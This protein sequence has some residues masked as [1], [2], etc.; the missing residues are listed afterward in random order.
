MHRPWYQTS[1]RLSHSSQIQCKC[2][3]YL[4]HRCATKKVIPQQLVLM[5]ALSKQ[6][7]TKKTLEGMLDP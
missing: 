4:I 5:G 3:S 1:M 2:Y 6:T 7:T